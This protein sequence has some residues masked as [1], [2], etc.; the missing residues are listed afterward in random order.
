MVRGLKMTGMSINTGYL[1]AIHWCNNSWV[2][3]SVSGG[4]PLRRRYLMIRPDRERFMIK[5]NHEC[6]KALCAGNQGISL[7]MT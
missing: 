5:W 3:A 2:G 6:N 4:K 7:C 1:D